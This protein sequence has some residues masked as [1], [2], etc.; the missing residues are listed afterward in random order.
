MKSFITVLDAQGIFIRMMRL[1]FHPDVPDV[2]GLYAPTPVMENI[3]NSLRV[4]G[5][6]GS[7]N[8]LRE[9]GGGR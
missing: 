5:Y 8:S 3:R 2:K 7:R 4:S 1:D 6:R 9:G